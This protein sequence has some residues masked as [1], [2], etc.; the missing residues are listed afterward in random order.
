MSKSYLE[1]ANITVPDIDAA[2]AFLRAVN[3]SIIMRRDEVHPEGYR[4]V[5]VS[6]GN[7]YI[8]LEEPHSKSSTLKCTQPYQDFGINHLGLVVDDLT[9]TIARMDAAG[10]KRGTLGENIQ[11]RQRVYYL[12]SAGMEWE[13]VEYYSNIESERYSYE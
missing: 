5:H 6:F 8:A 10:F 4:W 13:L 9:S 1:H 11:S 3:P 7:S 12:D 2:I